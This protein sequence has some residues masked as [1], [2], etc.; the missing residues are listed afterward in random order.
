MRWYGHILRHRREI[1]PYPKKRR[2]PCWKT[3]NGDGNTGKKKKRKT[4]KEMD[5]LCEGGPEGKRNR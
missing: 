4:E 2:G 5:R 1:V 3:D